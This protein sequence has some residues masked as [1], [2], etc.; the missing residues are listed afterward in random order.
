MAPGGSATERLTITNTSD[1]PF[2]LSLRA[3]GTQNR[4][5]DDLQMGVWQVGTAAPSPLPA[6][7]WWTTQENKITTLQSNQSIVLEIE[8]YLPTTAGNADQGL[9]AIIDFHWHAQA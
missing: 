9:A 7:L 6:L 3:S 5:W 2:D 4:L 1:Q 8:L